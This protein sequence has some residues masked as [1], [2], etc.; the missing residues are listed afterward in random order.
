M[1][2]FMNSESKANFA[3]AREAFRRLHRRAVVNTFLTRLRRQPIKLSAFQTTERTVVEAAP[4]RQDVRLQDI[5][6]SVGRAE[7]YTAS[8]LPLLAADEERWARV[9]LALDGGA[10]LPP[11]ELYA[12]DGTYYIKDGHHRVSVL[13]HLGMQWTEANVTVLRRVSTKRVSVTQP[14]PRAKSINSMF[15]GGC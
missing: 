10:G 15:C 6:G 1:Y 8:F 13:R 12:L 7:D 4:T 5:R 14:M 9:R 2:G 3:S 11:L